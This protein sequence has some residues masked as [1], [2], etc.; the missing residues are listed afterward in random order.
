MAGGDAAE[1]SPATAG[2]PV[3]FAEAGAP[4]W[5]VLIGPVVAVGGPFLDRLA[6]GGATPWAWVV[7]GAVLLAPIALIVRVRRRLLKVRVT[8]TELVQGEEVVPLERLV[9][10]RPP[11][12]SGRF[13]IKPFGDHPSV[14]RHLGAV[15]VTMDDGTRRAAWARDADGLHAA[16]SSVLAEREPSS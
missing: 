2:G 14:L 6:P 7:I 1:R 4:W 15:V 12:G 10:V 11:D 9:G 16:L 8:D 3:R 13:G 5:P